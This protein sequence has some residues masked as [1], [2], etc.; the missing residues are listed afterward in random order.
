MVEVSGWV[1]ALVYGGWVDARMDECVG[2]WEVVAAVTVVVMSACR[3]QR[4]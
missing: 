2:G 3:C 1:V 4:R